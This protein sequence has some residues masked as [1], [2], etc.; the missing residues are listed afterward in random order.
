[1]E[2]IDA[3]YSALLIFRSGEAYNSVH[4]QL[5]RSLNPHMET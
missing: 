2:L 3:N 5:A 1:M 4:R